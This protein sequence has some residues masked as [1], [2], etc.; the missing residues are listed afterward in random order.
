MPRPDQR[1]IK[2]L[3][4]L[5]SM[6]TLKELTLRD[7]KSIDLSRY[8]DNGADI[9]G[10]AICDMFD[11]DYFPCGGMC[12]SCHLDTPASVKAR[13]KELEEKK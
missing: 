3:G 7:L 2:T 8:D 9:I 13:I 4:G 6:K 12:Q 5:N 1:N 11:D 10:V